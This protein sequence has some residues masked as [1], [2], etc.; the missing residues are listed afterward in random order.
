MKMVMAI[1][2]SSP[3][4]VYYPGTLLNFLC[5]DKSAKGTRSMATSRTTVT[6]PAA[7]ATMPRYYQAFDHSSGRYSDWYQ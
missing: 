4:F 7:N 3:R 1:E 2:A 5:I 6:D